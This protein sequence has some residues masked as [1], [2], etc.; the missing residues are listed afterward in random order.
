MAFFIFF[1]FMPESPYY[2]LKKNNYER[3]GKCLAK[4]RGKTVQGVKEELNTLRVRNPIHMRMNPFQCDNLTNNIYVRQVAVEE[5][6]QNVG[7]WAEVFSVR[8]NR[9]AVGIMFGLMAVQQFS[10]INCVLF[11]RLFVLSGNF[12]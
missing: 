12:P 6:N 11:Y 2:E 4:L 5:S 1:Y 8:G 9:R 10:G 3:A 7:S